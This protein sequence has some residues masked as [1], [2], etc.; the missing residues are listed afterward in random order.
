MVVVVVV[1]RQVGCCTVTPIASQRFKVPACSLPWRRLP[2][3]SYI[4]VRETMLLLPMVVVV[5]VSRQVG[6]LDR[7]TYSF[8][9]LRGISVPFAA[10]GGCVQDRAT[11]DDAAAAA[12]DGCGGGRFQTSGMLY[13]YAYSFSALQGTCLLFAVAAAS[14]SQLHRCT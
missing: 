3:H 5:V 10:G 2:S 13:R 7:N 11:R 9:A 12:A 14:K 4:D 6:R 8:S 1:S